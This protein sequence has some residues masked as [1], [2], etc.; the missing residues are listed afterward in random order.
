M[1][2]LYLSAP[3]TFKLGEAP[4]PESKEGW[5]RVR[6][7]YV[8]IC[9][10]DVHY[11]VTGRIG[12][13]IVKYPY[14][15][16]HEC[17]GEVL[18]AGAGLDPGTPIYVEPAIPCHQCDQCRAGREHTCRNL[19]FLGNPTDRAGCMCEEIVIPL[20]CII[21]LPYAVGLD[22]A[23][24][25]EPMCI[26]VYA[27]MQSHFEPGQTAAIVGAGPIGLSVLLGLC[28]LNP[29]R[30]IVT[31]PVEAR[32]KAA[33]ALGAH[34]SMGPGDAGA[35]ETVIEA[36]HGGVDVSFEC[37]GTQESI[38]DAARML[39]PGGT[40]VLIGIPEGVDLRTYDPHMMRR[41]EITV[42]NIRR[43]NDAIGRTL[44][45]LERRRDARDILITHR[46]APARAKEA[47]DL[48]QQ[49]ADGVIKALLEF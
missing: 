18:D 28:K 15:L 5:V 29:S 31:E 4:A 14:I 19:L 25:L 16:G 9:G 6:V 11:Y 21:P 20:E 17:S 41:H 49:R 43:Q 30:L 8:G 46:F 22:E 40:L 1:R 45:I 23:V 47:F 42:V 48:V 36:S 34:L 24:L 10:S 3:Q 33:D 38:D 35:A 37:A 2:A 26:G 12:D 27:V 7:R 44:P 39:K 32:R 13:Q